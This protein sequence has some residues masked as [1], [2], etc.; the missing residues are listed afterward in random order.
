[1][2]F[3]SQILL[4]IACKISNIDLLKNFFFT[5]IWLKLHHIMSAKPV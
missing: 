1:M 3:H 5:I 4:R 2:G